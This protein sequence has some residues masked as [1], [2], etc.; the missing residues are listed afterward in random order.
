MIV[1]KSLSVSL[2]TFCIVPIVLKSYYTPGAAA[3]AG[4]APPAAFLERAGL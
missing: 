4:A 1:C 3:G 2:I